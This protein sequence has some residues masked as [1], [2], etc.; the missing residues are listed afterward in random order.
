MIELA[1]ARL[2]EQ[3]RAEVPQALQAEAMGV[4]QP[5]RTHIRQ[6]SFLAESAREEHD[7]D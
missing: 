3:L 7:D 6:T 4:P 1:P 5:S 2:Q